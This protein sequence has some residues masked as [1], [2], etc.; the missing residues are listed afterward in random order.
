MPTQVSLFRGRSRTPSL[1][2]SELPELELQLLERPAPLRVGAS[3]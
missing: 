3:T 1:P 2:T